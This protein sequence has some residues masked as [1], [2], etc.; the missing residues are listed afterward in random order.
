MKEK[1]LEFLA[2][3]KGSYVSGEHISE[4]LGISRAAVW[5]HMKALRDEGYTIESSSR[6]GYMLP[7]EADV[8]IPSEIESRL[9]TEFVGRHI[10]FLESIDSTNDHAKKIASKALDGTLVLADE[11]TKGKGRMD[12][13]WSS[14]KGE[15]VWMS[16][17]LKPNIAPHR[18]SVITLIAGAS[19]A[20]ALERFGADAKIKW[21]NDILLEGKKLCGILTEMSAQMERIDYIVLGIGINVSTMEFPDELRDI[22]TS[23]KR[24]GH[25]LE[26]RDIII[27]VLEE[28]E[29]M[30]SAYVKTGD[31]SEAI[32]ICREK[33]SLIGRDIYVISW[34]GKVPAK[35]LDISGEGDL[36]V[37]YEDGSVER[38]ISGEVSVRNR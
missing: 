37:E 2:Q 3:S 11:Q 27:A 24:E 15:G 14:Q 31:A 29:R 38:V 23:L 25:L 7:L 1:I 4:E 19:V 36:V 17:V 13:A 22:A 21:P 12:R 10:V 35:A 32:G 28:F 8:L 5:K 30:Y 9:D 16:L 33:S 20:R 26:R 18:A 34:S 6:R